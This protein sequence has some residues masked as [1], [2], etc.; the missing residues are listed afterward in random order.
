[1][2]TGSIRAYL[3][4]DLPELMAIWLAENCRAHGFIP[5]SYWLDHHEAV[6]AALTEAELYIYVS[7]TGKILGFAGVV[8]GYLAGLFVTHDYQHQGIGQRIMSDILANEPTL[9][10]D[11]YEKNT[12]ALNFYLKQGFQITDS[13]EQSETE[14]KE[15]RLIF[16]RTSSK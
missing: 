13:Q 6:A 7:E 5:E 15:L 12:Q 9:M 3:P 8:D 14:E 11:V 2:E 1:M 10:L 4:G 16:K